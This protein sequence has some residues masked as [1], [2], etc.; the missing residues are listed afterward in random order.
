MLCLPS[1][2]W[3]AKPGG[4][5]VNFN[6]I[7]KRS[8]RRGDGSDLRRESRYNAS[9]MQTSSVTK[10]EIPG[11]DLAAAGGANPGRRT[12]L[13]GAAAA[14]VGGASALRG[15]QSSGRAAPAAPLPDPL[16]APDQVTAEG[17]RKST[18]LNSSHL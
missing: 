13:L 3:S 1:A 2:S 18:R 12:F 6:D 4:V 17:D 14:V 10:R 15:E 11:A 5:M 9:A 7:A 8:V 16:R